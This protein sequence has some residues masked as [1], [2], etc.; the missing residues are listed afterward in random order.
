MADFTAYTIGFT[1]SDCRLAVSELQ[2]QSIA[3][4][5]DV[6]VVTTEPETLEASLQTGFASFR[7][8]KLAAMQTTGE[9]MAAAVRAARTDFVC[10]A[11]EH[12][13]FAPDWAEK[14]M[15]AHRRGYQAVGFAMENANP[16]PI[17]WTQLYGQFAPVVAPA[18]SGELEKLAGHHVSYSRA[19]LMGYGGNLEDILEDESALFLDLR[20]KGIALY[21]E[22]QAISR[23]VQ[24][25]TW[26]GLIGTDF[27]GHRTFAASR[28][29]LG[30]WSLPKRLF[31][32]A[33]APLVPLLRLQRIL[34]HILRAG[35]LSTL[36]PF[37]AVPMAVMLC[38]G[39]FGE[40][41]GY[42]FGAGA[43]AEARLPL[44]VQ[45]EQFVATKDAWSKD[46]A[47]QSASHSAPL[48]D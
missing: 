4:A 37:M 2:R 14:I 22:A 36:G 13:Y 34:P 28:W 41:M 20:A 8:I 32:A 38:A 11:E 21:L 44:E 31:Y 24:V 47:S 10:Y 1:A 6:I 40:A 12:S 23:H 16:G 30:H 5:M 7:F 3:P 43:S 27:H 19:L 33:A 48:P 45:R 9:A 18:L 35:R 17:S 15:Q 42:L 25:S 39:M 46:Q 29:K 26:A